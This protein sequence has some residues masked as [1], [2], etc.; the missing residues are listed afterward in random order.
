M[1]TQTSLLGWIYFSVMEF[2]QVF[3]NAI[4]IGGAS[5]AV[6]LGVKNDIKELRKDVAIVR[7]ENAEAHQRHE[8]DIRDHEQ[9][10]RD[11][12]RRHPRSGAVRGWAE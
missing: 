8:E 2:L 3:G 1:L 7:S 12:E 4:W 6:Y 11:I 10:L 9:R 5:V